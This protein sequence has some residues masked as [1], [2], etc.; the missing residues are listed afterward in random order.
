MGINEIKAAEPFE[1]E[2]RQA[3]TCVSSVP[4]RKFRLLLANILEKELDIFAHYGKDIIKTR[5]F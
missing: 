2:K 1:E 4:G 3:D 5:L